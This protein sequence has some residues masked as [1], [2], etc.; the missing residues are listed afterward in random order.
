[1]VKFISR[2]ILNYRIPIIILILGWVALLCTNLSKLE[3]ESGYAM[4]LPKENVYQL[5]YEEF[6]TTFGVDGTNAVIC[7]EDSNFY[8]VEKY[9]AWFRMGERLKALPWVDS[10]FSEANIM[11]LYKDDSLKQFTLKRLYSGQIYDQQELDSVVKI[12]KTLKFYDNALNPKGSNA[13]LMVAYINPIHVNSKIKDKIADDMVEA[14]EAE[15]NVFQS[16]YRYSGLPFIRA[17]NTKLVKFEI[18]L[19]LGL[20]ALAS[21][22]ILFFLFR[23]L[24]VVFIAGIIV[25]LGVIIALG[26]IGYFGFSV[27]GLMGLIPT[28]IIIIGVPNCVYL[29]NKYQSAYRETQDQHASL[30][31]VIHKIGYVMLLT[32]LT[33]ACGLSSFMF[34][35]IPMLKEFGVIAFISILHMFVITLAIVPIAYSFFPPPKEKHLKH[36]D[37]SWSN[38]FIAY[39]VRIVTYKRKYIY[40]S[41]VITLLLCVWG[42]NRMHITGTM[43]DDL[44]KGTKIVKDLQF[45]EREF[46]GVLPFEIIIDAKTDGQ[47]KKLKFQR[48]IDKIQQF[49][50]TQPEIAKSFSALDA[51]KFVNQAAHN[52]DSTFYR[53]PNTVD[54]LVIKRY[55]SQKNEFLSGNAFVDSTGT[56]I[57]ISANVADIG[58]VKM[59]HLLDSVAE[60]TI[61]ALNPKQRQT[62]SLLALLS[63]EDISIEDKNE[64]VNAI[65]KTNRKIKRSYIKASGDSNLNLLLSSTTSLAENDFHNLKTSVEENQVD[66][67]VSG[68]SLVIAKSVRYLAKNLLISLLIALAIIALLMMIL[69]RSLPMVILSLIPNVIPLV[70]AAALMGIADIPIKGSTMLVFSI[71]LGI[72]VD[73][74]I[75]FLAK[76]TQTLKQVN[77]DIEKAVILALKEMGMSMVYTSIILFAG[78]AVLICSSFGGTSATGMLASFTLFVA[79][80]TNLILL[81]S[82]LISFKSMLVKSKHIKK[83]SAN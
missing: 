51:A 48:K 74:A 29:I 4:S 82:L 17:F 47:I 1:M 2:L 49:L 69:F 20:A 21:V 19:F 77:G 46:G 57:R 11:N 72:S 67:Y 70:M 42:I 65:L 8:Q 54:K 6:K 79:M 55:F 5:Q 37:R 39:L 12:L 80:F 16:D 28:L 3:F 33:T 62:D 14:V 81:P 26:L 58:T 60:F 68:L 78:F 83:L 23:S 71:A 7:V 73:D 45:F 38:A 50:L 31:L 75:H 18:I 66:F 52:G 15:R 32:N 25:L 63:A 61:N 40:T 53:V 24:R 56:R 34:T 44:P 36:L 41:T 10:V 59:E 43:V 13:H 35:S 22:I 27:T 76:Y 30:E 64:H 9:N